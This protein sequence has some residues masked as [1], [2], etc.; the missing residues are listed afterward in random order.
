MSDTKKTASDYADIIGLP[1]HRSETHPH[2][3]MRDRAA[4]FAPFAALTGFGGVITEA[5]RRTDV[6]AELDENE[7]AE[8]DLRLRLLSE[9]SDHAP[10]AAVTYFRQDEHKT[11]GTYV[12]AEGHVKRVDPDERL[13][14]FDTGQRIRIDDIYS[15]RIREKSSVNT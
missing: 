12:T 1:H 11:G 9:R 14:V 7:Q 3:S 6:R 2:M 10:Y 13:L 5:G 4:Q 8:L 15:V